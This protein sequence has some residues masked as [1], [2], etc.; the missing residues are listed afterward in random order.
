MLKQEFPHEI[1]P[2][3]PEKPFRFDVQTRDFASLALPLIAFVC[4]LCPPRPV[5]IQFR[6]SATES[7]CFEVRNDGKVCQRERND[8][9]SYVQK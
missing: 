2:R 7:Q 5:W 4:H 8:G 3:K 9:K 6:C 1:H